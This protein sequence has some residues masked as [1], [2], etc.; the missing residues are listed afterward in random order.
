MPLSDRGRVANF[1]GG[2]VAEITSIPADSTSGYRPGTI[3]TLK[4]AANGMCPSWVNVGTLAACKFRTFGPVMGY[5]A[6]FG[7]GPVT[8]AGGDTT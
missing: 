1:K 8:S 3:L 4:D 7:G 2:I 6:M 5:G